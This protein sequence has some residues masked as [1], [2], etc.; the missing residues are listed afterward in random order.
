MSTEKLYLATFTRADT[1]LVE[2]LVAAESL[3]K[4]R[5]KVLDSCLQI[6]AIGSVEALK[7]AGAGIPVLSDDGA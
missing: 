6:R 5:A 1:D 4:A 3:A 2:V 7:I